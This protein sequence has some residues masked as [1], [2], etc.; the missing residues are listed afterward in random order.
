M[1]KIFVIIAIIIFALFMA[2]ELY[3]QSDLFALQIRPYVL[4]KLKEVLG[5]DAQIGWIRANLFP[6]YLEARDIALLERSGRPVAT[7]RKVKV[8][9]NPVPLLVKKVRLHSI[10]LQEPRI[11]AERTSDG[12]FN[13]TPILDRIRT[14]I[15]RIPGDASGFKVVLRTVSVHDGSISFTDGVTSAQMA[16]SGIQAAARVNI[17]GDSMIVALKHSLI[18]ISTPAYPDL[19]GELRASLRYDRGRIQLETLDLSTADTA[20]SLTGTI[21]SLPDPAL[22]LRV[23]ARS[24]P[25]TMDK[26]KGILKYLKKERRFRV[27]ASATVKGNLSNPA[28][29]GVFQLTGISYEGF[30]LQDAM[31]NFGYR[32]KQLAVNGGKWK[33]SRGARNIVV[34]SV[35]ALFAY[36]SHGVEIRRFSVRAGDLSGS[37]TGRADPKRGF[38]SVLSAESSGKGQ[39]LSFLTTVPVEGRI[40]VKGFLT[41][42]VDAPLVDG[43]LSA[44]SLIVRGIGFESAAGRIQYRDKTLNLVSVD[45]HQKS[46]RYVF[47]GSMDI[48]KKEP[49]FSARLKVIRSNVASIVA[50]FYEP[51]PLSIAATGDLSF[52]G[53]TRDFT[54]SGR[55]SVEAGSAYGEAFTK[56]IVTASL[57]KDRIAFPS[58]IVSKGS[59]TVNG[60]GWIGFNGTYEA[61]I[62][63]SDVRLEE[64]GLLA[65]SPLGG[66]F[67]LVIES[68]GS[69]SRPLVAATLEMDDLL[70]KQTSLGGMNADLKIRDRELGV[71]AHL[72]ERLD[73]QTRLGLNKPYAWGVQATVNS[74]GFDPLILSGKQELTGRVRVAAGGSVSLQ[75]RGSSIS[76]MT[77]RASFRRLSAVIGDYRIDND[78]PAELTVQGDR[79]LISSLNFSG[80][81]TKIAA[82]G[83]ARWMKDMDLSLSGNARLSLLRPLFR[84]L[85]HSDGTA[86]VKLSVSADDWRDPQVDGEVLVQNGEIKIKDVPQ[87][88]SGLNGKASFDQSRVVVER[89]TG[90]F[91]GGALTASGKAGLAGMKLQEFSSHVSFENVTVRY[92]EGLA[93]TLSGELYYDGDPVDQSLTGDVQIK[94]ARYDKRIEWKSM[95]VDIG[96]GLYQKKR[97]ETGW[98]G[99]T[100]INI[101]FYGKENILF[102]NN[103]AKMPLEVDVFLRGSVNHP[104]LLGRIEA[105][106]GSVYFRQNQFKIMHGSVDFVD[107]NRM[108]P[109]LDIQAEIQVREYLIRL[110]VSGT[111]DHA[112]V[113][114]L[115]D[116]QLP[117]SDILALLALGKTGTELKGRGAGVGM[118][119]AASFATGQFQDIFESRARSL[120]GLDRFQ[121][122]PYVSKG[123]SSVP[124]ITVGKEIVQDRLYV[125][126]SSNVGATIPEQIFRIEYVLNKHFSLVGERNEL[127]NTGAD[128]KYRFEFK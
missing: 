64:V 5:S 120:T 108:N 70:L 66:A 18:N 105:R 110:A 102:Q 33:I 25:Q 1:K 41:G 117:D 26:L 45:I 11:Y 123:D 98:V 48:G 30:L 24:G 122:D 83:S 6:L 81:G 34:D 111:A 23:R 113:T 59:G 119:E 94:R 106:K 67:H 43:E 92:P 128:L 99:D 103:L 121:V 50:L 27:E 82:T 53:T 51:L 112:V 87:K 65:G 8:Y 126:Y 125:T 61:A 115:S 116:P 13:G 72:G 15:A 22:N 37:V 107:P 54:G 35:D 75:G 77:G 36:S 93:S 89:L 39:T 31:L 101:R 9:I 47:N 3:V 71:T 124:R 44:D 79:L 21:G 96:K 63:S 42:A 84:D 38:D 62:E 19:A 2:A 80:E 46:S 127:G 4:A 95:L 85:E 28:A 78:G 58:V 109:V 60:T 55:L 20:V 74:D 57:T 32:D 40:S 76:G 10:V 56:G 73:L 12:R 88:F 14:N 97:T 7:L 100:Q 91:G 86:E 114:L 90:E 52:N 68:S 118:S 16:A 29:D 49:I 17:A 104:Q 69:F